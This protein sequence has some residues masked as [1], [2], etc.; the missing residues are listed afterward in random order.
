MEFKEKL[1]HK[2][3]LVLLVLKDLLDH[4][5]YK[6]KLDQQDHKGLQEIKDQLELLVLLVLKDP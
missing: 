4:K 3:L 5:V 6:V 2:E 1:D